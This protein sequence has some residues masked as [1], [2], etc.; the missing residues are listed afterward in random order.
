MKRVICLTTFISAT[1]YLNTSVP[2][3]SQIMTSAMTFSYAKKQT[4]ERTKLAEPSAQP[5]CLGGSAS[6]GLKSWARAEPRVEI[7]CNLLYASRTATVGYLYKTWRRFLRSRCLVVIHTVTLSS[8]LFELKTYFSG[9]WRNEL[10]GWHL[11]FIPVLLCRN[12]KNR[13]L[14]CIYLQWWG[15]VL[16]FLTRLEVMRQDFTVMKF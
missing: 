2:L 9:I 8:L 10:E 15:L 16:F 4:A 14:P 1:K 6:E 5:L 13:K 7:N 12:L 11:F 3:S